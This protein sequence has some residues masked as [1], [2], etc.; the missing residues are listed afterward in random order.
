METS[1]ETRMQSENLG[2]SKRIKQYRKSHNLT[3]HQLAAL[4]NVSR[5]YLGG[6]ENG[7][8][9]PS[10]HFLRCLL[11][12]TGL[13]SEWLLRGKK[14]MFEKKIEDGDEQDVE[15]LDNAEVEK[16]PCGLCTIGDMLFVPLS[17]IS[18][19]CGAGKM[20]YED[21]NLGTAVAVHRNKVGT[22][23]EGRLPFAVTT[24]GR[25]MEGYGIKEGSMVIVN[26][27]EPVQAGSVAMIIY[28]EKASI[29]KIYNASDGKYLIS[30][31]GHKIHV[32]NEELADE[33]GPRICGRVMVVISPPDDG[34]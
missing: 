31:S 17:S 20:V 30:S 16:L 11:D 3:Q 22:L 32:T 1:T 8:K 14:P 26:P 9:G 5:E 6:I 7:K 27:A 2:V 28:N 13:S 12:A 4:I 23:Q 19:C 21:Y 29:K 34:I 10:Y 15:A 25:S 33:W 24:E 18:A